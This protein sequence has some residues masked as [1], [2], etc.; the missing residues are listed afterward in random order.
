MGQIFHGK[1]VSPSRIEQGHPKATR[2]VYP[3]GRYGATLR[4]IRIAPRKVRLVLDQIRGLPVERA[5]EVLRYSSKRAA[6]LA[7]RVLLSAL[8]NAD[9]KSGGRVG[10]AELVV[11]DAY[12]GDGPRLSRWKAGPKG[13]ARPIIRRMSHISVVLGEVAEDEG[14]AGEA[15]GKKSKKSGAKASSGKAAKGKKKKAA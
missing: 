3:A 6:Y 14:K 5:R 4:N 13:G 7:D 1:V 15:P 12:C 9:V 2:R 11:A 8:G 10:A